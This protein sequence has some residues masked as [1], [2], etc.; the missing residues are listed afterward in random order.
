LGDIALDADCDG[1]LTADDCDDGAWWNTWTY[2][3]DADCDGVLNVSYTAQGLELLHIPV[4]S[5]DMGCTA[6]QSSCDLDEGTQLPIT[7][8]ND[9]WMSGTEVSQ[10]QWE[11]LM[12]NNPSLLNNGSCATCPVESVTWW[13]A[14]SFANEMSAAEGLDE[15]V[16]L[17]GCTG[18]A[19]VDLLCSSYTITSTSGSIYKCEGYRLPTEAE[20]EY[21][22]RAGLETLY[23]G[24]DTLSDVGWYSLNS[25][26]T[27]HAV[28]GY[29]P[30]P[31]GLYDMSGNVW[32][33]TW[34]TYSSDYYPDR[35]AAYD[36]DEQVYLF[37]KAV[38]DQWQ[39]D[40]A[41]YA[42][43]M[44]A[45]TNALGE[46]N[47]AYYDA[48]L[49]SCGSD[50][51]ANSTCWDAE[52]VSAKD[53]LS[54]T[55]AVTFSDDGAYED[56][57]NPMEIDDFDLPPDPGD[58]PTLP[59]DPDESDYYDDPVWESGTTGVLRG[60]SWEDSSN[61]ARVANR[62]EFELDTPADSLGFRL[63]RT[64]LS[65]ADLDGVPTDDDC[66]D[67]DPDNTQILPGCGWS[68]LRLKENIAA[69][70]SSRFSHLGLG[71]YRWTWAPVAAELYGLHGSSRGVLAQEVALVV[72]EAIAFDELGYLRVN[73]KLL[74]RAEPII[75]NSVNAHLECD[76]A[77]W[78]D[79]PDSR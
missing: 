51:S 60:G 48:A 39:I 58:Q 32:E 13:D 64:V 11:S 23:A 28:N 18:T 4:G 22:A 45:A 3:T 49:V 38:Y 2:S 26:G 43:A 31:W 50:Y 74:L 30:N 44:D 15:C 67:S 63:A 33:W 16:T 12:G 29:I 25:S 56:F 5:F 8:T 66:D 71:E 41:N 10:G 61:E 47:G 68:D 20:W 62:F 69:L 1:V 42:Q 6:G 55:Y 27:T 77:A 7:L 9:L 65:D 75:M 57:F 35:T 46:I 79:L 59:P 70:G 78:P 40:Y 72:P 14:L 36:Y 52:F 17:N 54:I 34:D 24:S 73:Y 53:S 21:A 37:M 76:V 19:G